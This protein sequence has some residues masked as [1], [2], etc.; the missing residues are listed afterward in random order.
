MSDNLRLPTYGGQA[1]IEGVLMKG[2]DC[3]AVVVRSPQGQLLTHQEEL[4]TRQSRFQSI[5]KTPFIRGLFILW[6]ALSLGIKFLTY[7]A[8]IQGGEDEKI[9]GLPLFISLAI[10]LLIVVGLFFLL[11][12]ALGSGIQEISAIKS[13]LSN[14]IEG[15]VRLT[16]LILYI[17]GI[18]KMPDIQRVFAYHGAEHKTINAFEARANL[19]IENLKTFPL[20]HPR[21]GT[22]FLLTV[23]VFSIILFSLLGP[24]SVIVKM[25]SRIVAI[26]LLASL[27]YEYIRWT[28]KHLTSPIIKFLYLPNLALQ[29]LTTREPDDQMLEVALTAF[30]TMIACENKN[31]QKEIAV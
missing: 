24:M 23:V 25:I 3:I 7:S 14:V 26:P 2:A 17:W 29:R 4:S 30:Q 22:S 27:A 12:A 21:C 1:L 28:S 13:W 11:P 5:R 20:I 10:S 6:D 16:I 8:N 15:I 31:S 18:G 19:T 9:E